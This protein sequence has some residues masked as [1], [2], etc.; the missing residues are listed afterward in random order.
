MLSLPIRLGLSLFALSAVTTWVACG[1]GAASPSVSG[2]AY[3]NL[4]PNV[5]PPGVS[6]PSQAA[7][8]R[9]AQ[10]YA[11]W[12]TCIGT[13]ANAPVPQTYTLT[14]NIISPSLNNDGT[15]A[16]Y[17]EDGTAYGDVMWNY[18]FGDS[19]ATHFVIDLFLMIDQPDNVQA[20]E[21]ALLKN[22]GLNWYKTST[23]CNYQSGN[24]R[25]FDVLSFQWED[26][27][28]NC[29]RA[30][31]N[32]WQRLTLQYSI[33]GGTTNFEGVSFNGVLQP[34]NVSLPPEPQTTAS[35]LMGIHVQLDNA[36]TIAGYTLYLDDWT[37]YSW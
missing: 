34:I 19:T 29:V 18:H 9:N 15:S 17:F 27:G 3:N 10:A 6:V 13:C 35:E 1:S 30:Q 20:L 4:D 25:G 21:F 36:N 8:I 22:D 14:Q 32:T 11:G 16:S 24:L 37:V 7:I 33:S 31:A 5:L 28:A 2:S 26:L 23:Q 12:Q